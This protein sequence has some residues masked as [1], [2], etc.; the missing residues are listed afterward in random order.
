MKEKN[1]VFLSLNEDIVWRKF[2]ETIMRI[3]VEC[4]YM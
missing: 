3:Y 1:Q 4:V 2:I